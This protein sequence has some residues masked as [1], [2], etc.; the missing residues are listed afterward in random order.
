[1][2]VK[3]SMTEKISS[4]TAHRTELLRQWATKTRDISEQIRQYLIRRKEKVAWPTT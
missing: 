3:N 2:K 4:D 1:M